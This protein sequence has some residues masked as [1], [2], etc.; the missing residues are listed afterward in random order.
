MAPD[1]AS[2][3]GDCCTI[4]AQAFGPHG[5]NGPYAIGFGKPWTAMWG[6]PRVNDPEAGRA[7]E[8]K[9]T[10]FSVMGKCVHESVVVSI[11]LDVF[12]LHMKPILDP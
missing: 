3:S 10:Y 8:S 9:K 1:T 12:Q 5:H 6:N 7:V 2:A 11:S 4:L